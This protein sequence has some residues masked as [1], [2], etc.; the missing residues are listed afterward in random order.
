MKLSHHG[1]RA[2][3]SHVVAGAH[4]PAPVDLLQLPT[5]VARILS[6]SGDPCYG[7]IYLEVA[8]AG[9]TLVTELM[10]LRSDDLSIH[11][12]QDV[13]LDLKVGPVVPSTFSLE[14]RICASSGAWLERLVPNLQGA[15]VPDFLET[16]LPP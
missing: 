14:G 9:P 4:L 10:V 6:I 5:P 12:L 2:N 13:Q 11:H 3:T 7:D 15:G 16:V 1:S 8:R